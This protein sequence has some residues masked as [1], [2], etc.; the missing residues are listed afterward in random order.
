MFARPYRSFHVLFILPFHAVARLSGLLFSSQSSV[1]SPAV[2]T[3][4]VKVVYT[5]L[6]AVMVSALKHM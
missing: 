3:T 5:Y 4:L 6:A 2:W 1:C